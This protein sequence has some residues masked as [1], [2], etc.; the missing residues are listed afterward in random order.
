QRG[1]K[2]L[3]VLSDGVDYGSEASLAEAIDAAQRADTLVYSIL[4]SDRHAFSIGGPDGRAALMR[5]SNDT[6]GGFF[7]VSK[8][9]N[10]E[11]IFDRI[12]EELRSQYSI[13]YV[14]DRPTRLSEFRKIRLT[15][16]RKALVVRARDK[17][18]A[19]L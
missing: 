19:Q 13:G 8:K 15:T 11:Q 18:W 16:S 14:S 5:C 12:Q 3:I 2:T 4:F 9:L 1:R 10:I 17:Y 6:G 7:E